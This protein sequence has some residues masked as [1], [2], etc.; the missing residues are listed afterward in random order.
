MS[1][2]LNISEPVS[3]GPVHDTSA[4]S[5]YNQ[6]TRRQ[7]VS[8][9]AM[10]AGAAA[11]IP[12]WLPRVSF[13]SND[14]PGRD[15]ILSVYLRGGWDGLSVCVPHAENRYYTLRP[16]ISVGRPDQANGCLD[17][18][19]FFGLNPNMS[20]FLPMYQAGHL[21]VV[22]ACGLTDG[23][24]SHFDA[25]RFMELGK[26]QD[27]NLFT[28]WLGR[29]IASVPPND[30]TAPIRAIAL[31]FQ[32]PLTLSGAPKG[33]PVPD[34]T[35]FTIRGSSTTRTQRLDLL[36]QAY[37]GAPDPM[38]A[39]AQNTQA[40]INALAAVNAGSYLPPRGT[41]AYPPI[42]G[43]GASSFSKSLQQTAALIRA[44][45]GVEAVAIDK[46]GWDTHASQGSVT[47][48]M[49]S[50]LKDT[51]DSL[52]AFYEDV[53]IDGGFN[54]TIV[55]MSEFGRRAAQNGSQGTDHGYGNAMITIGKGINGGQVYG[56]WPGLTNLFQ[57][58]DLGITTDYRDV[59][60]EIVSKR[61]K[62][63]NLGVVFPDYTPTF[64]NIAQV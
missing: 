23:T 26:A 46:G 28:G 13:A 18:N 24:R 54:V 5:E 15:I 45:I 9:S 38:K 12:S 31:G 2:E 51:A 7:F 34:M 41:F 27:P 62:N 50:N 16:D 39:A 61:L 42:T 4:C 59:L 57:N 32:L 10:I 8:W 44:N 36:T 48:T 33:L 29:H 64:R 35:S 1:D 53:I 17:L 19:G 49:A 52:R 58:L 21:A 47:G 3:G 25:Q 22:H 63:S 37:G 6:L 40:T 30:P 43:N 56:T 14:A 20:A 60:A 11:T 55:L